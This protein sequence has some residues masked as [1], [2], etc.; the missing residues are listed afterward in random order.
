MSNEIKYGA[1]AS[2]VLDA[3]SKIG[4]GLED[5]RNAFQRLGGELQNANKGFDALNKSLNTIVSN[6][7]GFA[8]RIDSMSR[9]LDTLASNSRAGASSLGSLGSTLGSLKVPAFGAV[10][11]LST[12]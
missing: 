6:G 12:G 10:G 1:D 5:Q 11:A 7:P 2:S 9:S 4:K 8:A 3:L